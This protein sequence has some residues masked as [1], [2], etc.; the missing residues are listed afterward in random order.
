MKTSSL[1]LIQNKD[2][3]KLYYAFKIFKKV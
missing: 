3:A 1:S 2:I